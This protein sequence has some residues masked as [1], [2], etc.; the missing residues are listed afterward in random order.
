[1]KK[2]WFY[3]MAIG[4]SLIISLVAC[5]L[6]PADPAGAPQTED[7][8]PPPTPGPERQDPGEFVEA[9][10]H[11]YRSYAGNVLAD[12]A[13]HDTPM[14]S[15]T[16]ANDVDALVAG[17]DRGGYDPFICAQNP[18]GAIEV[19]SITISGDTA[20]VAVSTD[21]QGHTFKVELQ[22]IEGSEWQITDI[23]CGFEAPEEGDGAPTIEPTEPASGEGPREVVAG[24]PVLIDETYNF[25][26]QY[27]EGWTYTDID[28]D[29]PNQ[30]P[31]GKMAR[32]VHLQPEDWEEPFI[33]LQMEVYDMDDAAFGAEFIPG[34]AEEEIVR[35]DGTAYTK[36]THDFGQFQMY[37]YLFRSPT[38]PNIRVIFTDY[39][40][41][42]P[43]RLSGN[44]DVAAQFEPILQSFGFTE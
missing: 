2:Q 11:W 21:L 15:D 43:D 40:T 28:L 4:F 26:V 1:M 38:N 19:E 25:I 39:V 18:P 17:F 16:F 41:G 8:A 35:D 24:W 20:E 37:Q 27:P 6:V 22:A 32:L 29:D 13:Y 42:W 23:N 9:F 5:T 34:T 10:Y 44:E 30:P 12:K 14:V 36:V 7:V 31:A 33:A 3:L